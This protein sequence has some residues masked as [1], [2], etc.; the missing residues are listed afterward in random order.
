MSNDAARNGLLAI[1]FGIGVLFLLA[2]RLAMRLFGIDPDEGRLAAYATRYLGARSLLLGALLAGEP[3]G[4]R[5]VLRLFP[6]I[7][8]TDATLNILAA[9]TGEAPRRTLLMGSLTSVT[10]VALGLSIDE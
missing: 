9:R 6:L 8:A 3:G 2:P 1:N 5:A 4:R 7:A 10:A